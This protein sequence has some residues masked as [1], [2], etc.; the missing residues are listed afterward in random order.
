METRYSFEVGFL[1]GQKYEMYT[2]EK[3]SGIFFNTNSLKF[4]FVLCS[5]C[6]DTLYMWGGEYKFYWF[7]LDFDHWLH[8]S[9][10]LINTTWYKPDVALVCFKQWAKMP[11][12]HREKTGICAYHKRM[13]SLTHKSIHYW[14][15]INAAKLREAGQEHCRIDCSPSLPCGLSLSQQRSKQRESEPCKV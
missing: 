12:E 15:P 9:N 10:I 13:R 5:S 11:L 4:I 2:R 6:F 1:E 7:L 8:L 14:P 3:V